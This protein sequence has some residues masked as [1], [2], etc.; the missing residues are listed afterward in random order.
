MS[1]AAGLVSGSMLQSYS[2]PLWS[3]CS[4]SK[5]DVLKHTLG[6]RS[7]TYSAAITEHHCITVAGL[8]RLLDVCL[9]ESHY[10]DQYLILSFFMS[11]LSRPPCLLAAVPVRISGL[12]VFSTAGKE[13]SDPQTMSRQASHQ[14][15]APALHL[16]QTANRTETSR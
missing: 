8:R 7:F 2:S 5:G 12:P 13:R 11:L 3:H 15:P 4:L 10:I 14:T 1:A 16:T 6:S 9:G